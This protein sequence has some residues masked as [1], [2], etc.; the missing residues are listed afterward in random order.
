MMLYHIAMMLYHGF[1]HLYPA[2]VIWQTYL[3]LVSVKLKNALPQFLATPT[4]I[5]EQSKLLIQ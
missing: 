5:L 2:V 4:V 3:F 1:Y